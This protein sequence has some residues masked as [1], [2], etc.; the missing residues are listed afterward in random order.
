MQ[1]TNPPTSKEH[2]QSLVTVLLVLRKHISRLRGFNSPDIVSAVE[3]YR[4]L[5]RDFAAELRS[6]DPDAL[7][8]IVRGRES[9]L[10]AEAKVAA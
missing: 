3:R 6:L 1:T 4:G 10:L 9:W 8:R 7:A 5:F 2:V